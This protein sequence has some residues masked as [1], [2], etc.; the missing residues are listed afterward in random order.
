MVCV[1]QIFVEARGCERGRVQKDGT[2]TPGGALSCGE[3]ASLCL[4]S[5]D[6]DDD[7]RRQD[8][9]TRNDAQS[10]VYRR[11]RKRE[12]DDRTERDREFNA[13]VL[14]VVASYARFGKDI[15][16]IFDF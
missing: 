5:L 1:L 10:A 12:R 13:F 15:S 6:N 8:D 2:G 16:F 11:E 4:L 14:S 3:R 9:Q 7:E